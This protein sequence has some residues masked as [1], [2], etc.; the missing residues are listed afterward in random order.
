MEPLLEG[1]QRETPG[2]G[3]RALGGSGVHGGFSRIPTCRKSCA[4]QCSLGGKVELQQRPPSTGG[5]FSLKTPKL[6]QL[7]LITRGKKTHERVLFQGG[8]VRF[9]RGDPG[10]EKGQRDRFILASF[11]ASQQLPV[12]HPPSVPF[13]LFPLSLFPCS[14]QSP[15]A[16]PAR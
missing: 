4:C 6:P 5:K 3:P 9:W 7:A 14:L 13:S 2:I 11:E 12:P 15:G 16:A 1:G 8:G 10:M